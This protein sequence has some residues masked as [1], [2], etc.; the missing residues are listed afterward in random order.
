MKIQLN[1]IRISPRHISIRSNSLRDKSSSSSD[2]FVLL[3]HPYNFIDQ[4]VTLMV[5]RG[6]NHTTVDRG[7]KECEFGDIKRSH[8]TSQG[9]NTTWVPK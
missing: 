4:F 3:N 9:P 6:T 7:L 2:W 8:L 1:S 5:K